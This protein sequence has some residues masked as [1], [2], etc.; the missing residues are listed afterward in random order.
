MRTHLVT[1]LLLVLSLMISGCGTPGP[2]V[3]EPTVALRIEPFEQRIDVVHGRTLVI[4]VQI[5]GVPIPESLTMR[6]DDRRTVEAK[7][8]W[9]SVAPDGSLPGWLPP[10]GSWSVQLPQHAGPTGSGWWVL[11]LDLPHDAINQNAW[12][13]DQVA[14]PGNR[15]RQ[16]RTSETRLPLHWYLD[17]ALLPGESDA[18]RTPFPQWIESPDLRVLAHADAMS[19]LRRW[20]YRLLM[21]DSDGPFDDPV[22]EA[23]ASQVEA[24]WRIGLGM[25]WLSHPEVAARLKSRLAAVVDFGDGHT[26]PAYPLDEVQLER[27]LNDLLDQKLSHAERAERAAAWLDALPAGTAWIVD[28]AGARDAATGAR[29]AT[30]GVANLSHRDVV[31]SGGVAGSIAPEMRAVPAFAARML[32]PVVVDSGL[33]AAS[34]GARSGPM[35]RQLQ[36]ATSRWSGVRAVVP[37]AIPLFPPGLRLDPLLADWTLAGWL[38]GAADG[39]MRVPAAWST[40]ILL[41]HRPAEATAVENANPKRGTWLLHIECRAPADAHGED[42]VDVWLGPLGSP[43]AVLHISADRPVTDLLGNRSGRSG[44]VDGVTITR[45]SDRWIAQV[46]IAGHLVEPQGE[47]LIGVVRTD[48]R[49]LRSAWPRPMLP[50]QREPGRLA[51]D[52]TA[53]GHVG[54]TESI[55]R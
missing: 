49:G 9:I 1:N 36:F 16:V 45:L 32:S 18:W 51:V 26:A 22:I 21:G 11:V 27:L 28:D 8:R 7:V 39:A 53:W 54:P 13:S 38:N 29:V 24:R 5:D 14:S 50:W 52:T 46:P 43:S 10:A 31:A 19:P 40:A 37:D 30:A 47:L 15:Q 6:L 25:L 44:V 3:T 17:A 55:S 2:N 23:F 48:G 12:I 42:T 33:P 35:S 41:H 34:G 20:R 4:P